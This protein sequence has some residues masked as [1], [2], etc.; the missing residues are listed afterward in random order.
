MKLARYTRLEARHAV[1]RTPL[2]GLVVGVA[3]LA[4]TQVLTPLLPAAAI[5]FLER[6]F[7]IQGLGAVILLND[8]LAL[9]TVLFFVGV[10]QLQRVTIAP[11]EERHLDLLL[12]K[13][14]SP[15]RLL[16]ARA[17]PVLASTLGLGLALSAGCALAVAP[18]V[19]S[20]DGTVLGALSA[21]LVVSAAT[22][23]Q[24]ALVN[25]VF[26]VLAD[27]FQALLVAFV[28]WVLPLMPTSVFLYRPDLF[29]GRAALTQALVVPANLIWNDAAGPALAIGAVLAAIAAGAAAVVAGGGLLARTETR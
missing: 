18:Y 8:Y 13:P 11:R 28:A 1:G 14:V 2:V 21:G 26:L 10:S 25:L 3:L 7:H 4:L 19:G 12:S 27:G 17:G 5:D 9:S 6:A 24:L 22:V 23:V 16:A 20:G 29:E 15:R